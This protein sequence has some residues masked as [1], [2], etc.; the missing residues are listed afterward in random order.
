MLEKYTCLPDIQEF[1]ELRARILDVDSHRVYAAMLEQEKVD[2]TIDSLVDKMI[3]YPLRQISLDEIEHYDLLELKRELLV[4]ELNEQVSIFGD[5]IG[6]ANDPDC[7]SEYNFLVNALNTDAIGLYED[8]ID[9]ALQL[10]DVFHPVFFDYSHIENDVR[11][12]IRY[13]GYVNEL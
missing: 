2:D 3:V 5:F 7:A 12:I 8:E 9:W 10:L 6:Y 11:K 4:I 13:V 1:I